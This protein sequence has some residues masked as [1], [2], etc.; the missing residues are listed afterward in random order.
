MAEWPEGKKA[1]PLFLCICLQG[2][3][4]LPCPQQREETIVRMAEVL[5]Y[6]PG[7]SAALSRLHHP[8]ESVSVLIG[9]T[10][11]RGRDASHQDALV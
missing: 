11:E 6:L 3:E 4:A 10:V 8:L 9:A 1:P 7:P 2:V 5:H